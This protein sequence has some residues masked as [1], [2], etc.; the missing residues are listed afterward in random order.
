MIQAENAYWEIYI[1]KLVTVKLLPI[2]MSLIILGK[3][4]YKA[5]KKK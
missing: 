1:F 5:G 3:Y 2:K 4:L